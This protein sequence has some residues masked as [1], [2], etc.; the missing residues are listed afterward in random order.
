MGKPIICSGTLAKKPYYISLTNQNVYSIEELCF[1]IRENLEIL[2]EEIF[3]ESLGL[4]IKEE[5]QLTSRGELLLNLLEKKASLKDL[6]VCILCSCDYYTEIEIKQCITK[7]DALSKLS[8]FEK[9]KQKADQY[10]RYRKYQ[11]AREEYEALC[12]GQEKITISNIEYGTLLH[13]LAIAKIH[14]TGIATALADFKEAYDRS[15]HMASLKQYIQGLLL[16][17][18]EDMLQ[19]ALKEYGIKD[20]LIEQLKEELDIDCY[21]YDD[22]DVLF[23]KEMIRCKESGKISEFYQLAEDFI[24]QLKEEFRQENT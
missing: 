16:L 21:D 18:K 15:K 14:T 9:K 1:Y 4:W 11:R 20:E 6:A 3:T 19:E 2:H 12:N 24:N 8:P 10:L 7:L 22:E 5:L 23:V 17:E 13:N